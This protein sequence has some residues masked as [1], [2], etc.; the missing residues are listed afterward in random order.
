MF[1]FKAAVVGAGTMGGQIA[2]TIA[3]AGIP[4]LLKDIDR[5][6][7]QAGLDEARKVTEGQVGK[8]VS[9]E[10]ITAEQ[11]AAQIEEVLGRI[12]GTT[13]YEGFGDVDFVIEAVP[14]RMEIKQAVFA[15]LD[16]VTPGH[17]ILASNTS[18]LSIG[19]IGEATLRPE[20]VVGFHYFYPA[21][22]MPLVEI[23]EGE[24]TSPETLTAALTFAQAIRKQPIACLEVP[25]FVVNRI[26]MAGMSELWREQET[27]KL[28]IKAMDEGIAAAG[29]V[30]MGPYF[31]VNLLGLDTVLHVAKHVAGAY[32]D[33]RFY[34]PKGMQKLVSEGKLG[35]KTGGDGVYSP[36]GEPNLKGEEEPDVDELVELLTLKTFVEAALVLQEG[37]ATHRDID[38]GMMAGAGLDPRRGLM[39]PFM[40]A[41]AE[42]LDSVLERLEDAAES[43]GERFA[44]PAI[45]RRLVAQGRL[46]Q[47]SGQGFYAYP[48]P[49]AEQPGEV[50]KLETR[51]DGVAI[52]WL[53]NGQMNSIAPQVIEDL[54]KVWNKVE[55]S[56][57]HALVIA[58]SNPFLFSAGADIKAFTSMDTDSGPPAQQLIHAA[59]ALLR[60]LETAGVATIAAVNGL[61]FGGGCELA[62][63]CDVRI[64]ARSAIFGQPEIKLGIIPGFGGTQRLPRLVGENKALEMN[65]V[66]DP[67]MAEE[68]FELGL[69]NRMVEDHE[70]LDTALS[71]ARRLASQAPVALEQIKRVSGAGDLDEGIEAEK[72]AFATAFAS[73]D[74]KEG[75]SAFLGKRPPS[76]RGR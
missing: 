76:F 64:A 36:S 15:E 59:H 45:L 13:S 11:G 52:A 55:S 3:A 70:L 66:G 67:I 16:A 26:L 60:E 73:E 34:V 62:M 22:A 9:K 48:Q 20:K 8:L 51:P 23:V 4:V 38:F 32:G 71:W 33:E 75:I 14:E 61:A 6:L 56:D 44:P 27:R 41:D 2:Q 1:V 68:A 65:L 40:K 5:E 63:A 21:S 72:R 74:A 10:R 50:V 17:A 43:H 19:E 28:S 49:D 29:V 25:G 42:G 7:V 54:G 58:S 35:A 12:D 46:G 57:V 53:A 24:E 47:K 69:V 31:L 18:S 37:V 30:P 39:P